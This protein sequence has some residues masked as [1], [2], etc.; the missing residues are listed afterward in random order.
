MPLWI[1]G[2]K[3]SG[4]TTRISGRGRLIYASIMNAYKQVGQYEWEE[5]WNKFC[6]KETN[7]YGGNTTAALG[8]TEEDIDE[9]PP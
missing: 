9:E 7:N 5:G 2:S 8:Q 3:S 6:R 4:C 1:V